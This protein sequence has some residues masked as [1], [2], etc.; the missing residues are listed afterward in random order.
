MNLAEKATPDWINRLAQCLGDLIRLCDQHAGFVSAI[1]T[2][3]YVLATLGLVLLGYRQFRL[4]LRLER[5]R[6]RPSV[7]IDMVT[8]HAHV[9]VTLKNLGQTPAY[10]VRVLANPE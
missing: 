1:L 6:I 4:A 5:S 8:A 3:V 10:G 7:I 9:H 2:G